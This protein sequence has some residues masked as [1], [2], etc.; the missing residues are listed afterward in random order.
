MSITITSATRRTRRLTAV[1]LL[2]L[3][4]PAA[5]TACSSED[6]GTSGDSKSAASSAPATST[7]AT[8][9]ADATMASRIR[10]SDTWAKA[11][12]SG[13]SAAFGTLKN[14]GT[15]PIVVTG[16]RG[17]AGPVQ[18]HV[19]QKTA[20]GMEM[21][22][23]KSFTVPA[24]GS[25]ELKPGSSHL[26]FMNLSHALKAGETQK[27]TVTFED[28]SH[29]DVSFPVRAYD[30]AKE[31]YAGSGHAQHS[32]EA[33]HS[34]DAHSSGMGSHSAGSTMPGMSTTPSH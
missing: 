10:P 12:D 19:T 31:K 21:K 28:G 1:A 5:L 25:L 23:T 27:L 30:G 16:A 3:A 33:T 11:A 18:L 6:S 32:S 17:D 4:A 29:T 34:G 22:E 15:K 9:S 2:T 8:S 13:M 24:G 20:T 7:S 26:M 14:T